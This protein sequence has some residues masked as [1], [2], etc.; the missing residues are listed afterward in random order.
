MV[1][2]PSEFNRA[3]V[4]APLMA[5]NSVC[6]VPQSEPREFLQAARHYSSRIYVPRLILLDCQLA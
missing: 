4:V 3:E 5:G 2:V 1:R 6:G